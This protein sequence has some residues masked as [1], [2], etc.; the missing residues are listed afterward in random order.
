M[1]RRFAQ[2]FSE[3]KQGSDPLCKVNIKMSVLGI[4]NLINKG[5]SPKITVKITNFDGEPKELKMNSNYENDV[6]NQND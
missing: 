1:D 2:I 3:L 5:T 6:L 4:R